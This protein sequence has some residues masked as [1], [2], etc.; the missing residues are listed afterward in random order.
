[1]RRGANAEHQM[2]LRFD[3]AHPEGLP[4]NAGS[5]SWN[6][7]GTLESSDVTPIRRQNTTLE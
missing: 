2:I 5:I 3:L 7:V 4:T 1:M 6:K